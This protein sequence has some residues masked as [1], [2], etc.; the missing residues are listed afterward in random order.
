MV[1]GDPEAVLGGQLHALLDHSVGNVSG[2]D[3]VKH[4]WEEATIELMCS[5]NHLEVSKES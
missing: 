1:N 5:P 2:E 3:T 4:T